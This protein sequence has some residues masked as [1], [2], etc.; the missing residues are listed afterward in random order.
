MCVLLNLMLHF[1]LLTLP[2]LN[3]NGDYVAFDNALLS[4]SFNIGGFFVSS[5]KT[6]VGFNDIQDI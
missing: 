2:Y 3:K 6:V 1:V 5:L 4:T